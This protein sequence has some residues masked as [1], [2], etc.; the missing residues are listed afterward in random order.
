[1]AFVIK[2]RDTAPS[3]VVGLTDEDGFVDLAAATGVKFL[4]RAEGADDSE[5]PVVEGA[6]A[7]SQIPNPDE[8]SQEIWVCTYEWE[9]GDLDL[10]AGD[11]N[12]EFE[13]DWGGGRI[14]TFPANEE[15]PYMTVK[16]LEDL[17]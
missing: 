4:M 13:V 16:V 8:P 6:M 7:L 5:P 11:Y 2:Q 15:T 17:G 3:Y 10:P 9:A 14:E 1:M 12:A